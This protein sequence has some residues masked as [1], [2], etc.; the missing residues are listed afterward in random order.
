[1]LLVQ[2]SSDPTDQ[3]ALRLRNPDLPAAGWH[4]V[5]S[6]ATVPAYLNAPSIGLPVYNT[7]G[8]EVAPASTGLYTGYYQDLTNPIGFNQ[9]GSPVGG[10][11]DPIYV[12]NGSA[13]DGTLVGG[14]TLSTLTPYYGDPRTATYGWTVGGTGWTNSDDGSKHFLPLYALSTPITV[15]PEPTTVTLLGSALLLIGGHRF[16]RWRRGLGNGGLASA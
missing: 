6:T 5:A 13:P 2:A 11:S 9:F 16:L 3:T 10:Y 1:V 4:A 7:Q 15:V 8:Q 12:W 14:F